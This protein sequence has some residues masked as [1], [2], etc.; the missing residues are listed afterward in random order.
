VKSLAELNFSSHPIDGDG[1]AIQSK[2]SPWIGDGLSHKNRFSAKTVRTFDVF[3]CLC[4]FHSHSYRE[5]CDEF[6]TFPVFWLQNS[7]EN[8]HSISKV[9]VLV[10][11]NVFPLLTHILESR[12]QT[13]HATSKRAIIYKLDIRIASLL[14]RIFFFS[15]ESFEQ[16]SVLK[17][18]ND[19][20]DK[21]S[22]INCWE[23]IQKSRI[24]RSNSSHG[25]NL[26]YVYEIPKSEYHYKKIDKNHSR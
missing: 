21:K 3:V 12:I 4:S 22:V 5:S 20:W 15:S 10:G 6:R 8:F 19:L 16:E 23:M 14:N 25:G 18:W 13:R 26:Y 2:I 1:L 11:K 9:N 7:L 24:P 17:L